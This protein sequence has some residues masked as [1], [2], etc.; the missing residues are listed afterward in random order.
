MYGARGSWYQLPFLIFPKHGCTPR[1]WCTQG[2][3]HAM[4]PGLSWA[5]AVFTS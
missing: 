4:Q 3:S 2:D 1:P 5:F